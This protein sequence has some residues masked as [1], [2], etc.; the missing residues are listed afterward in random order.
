MCPDG[1]L[2]R[3][4]KTKAKEVASSKKERKAS[5]SSLGTNPYPERKKSQDG[6][7]AAATQEPAYVVCGDTRR[8]VTF[9]TEFPDG[10]FHTQVTVGDVPVKNTFI[11]FRIQRDEDGKKE[12]GPPTASAPGAMLSRLFKTRAKYA[13]SPP[14]RL[15][16]S[17]IPDNPFGE[18]MPPT[19]QTG[20][21]TPMRP[22]GVLLDTGG[23]AEPVAGE[24]L[25]KPDAPEA[26]LQG[27][28]HPMYKLHLTKE[29]TPCNYFYYKADGCRQGVE[30]QFCHLCPKGEIKKRKKERV[31]MLKAQS[32]EAGGGGDAPPMAAF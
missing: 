11:D 31:K 30:C 32:A 13:P 24:G 22:P 1:E 7:F 6:S 18:P 28:G 14:P 19:P 12:D 25:V 2:K 4:K 21:S 17:S 29:C 23:N 27:E 20:T 26:E 8:P 16:I 5:V 15:S 3:R 9:D 10:I